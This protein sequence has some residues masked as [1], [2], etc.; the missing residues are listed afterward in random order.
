MVRRPRRC[1]RAVF[2]WP[3]GYEDIKEDA[4]V[5]ARRAWTAIDTSHGERPAMSRFP[6]TTAIKRL[7][8]ERLVVI[9]P[10]HGSSSP[11]SPARPCAT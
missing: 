5:E 2:Q 10:Q 4:P 3:I 6:I 8:Y 1:N 7:A 11:R 9:E